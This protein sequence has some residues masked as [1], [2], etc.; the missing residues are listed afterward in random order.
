MVL[1]DLGL[2]NGSEGWCHTLLHVLVAFAFHFCGAFQNMVEGVSYFTIIC[3]S[4]SSLFLVVFSGLYGEAH[5]LHT[6]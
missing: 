2:D 4:L 5:C 6:V 3:V 1:A